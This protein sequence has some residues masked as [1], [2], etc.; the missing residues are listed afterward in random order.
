MTLRE[1]EHLGWIVDF[2]TGG[3][4]YDVLRVELRRKI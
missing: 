3:V 1:I 2:V 4:H